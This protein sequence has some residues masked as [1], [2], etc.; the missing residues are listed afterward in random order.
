MKRLLHR[1][2]LCLFISL[3]TFSASQGKGFGDDLKF[4]IE[5][6]SSFDR[7][8]YFNE[9]L[10][11]F[12]DF[13]V[14]NGKR[15]DPFFLFTKGVTTFLQI[16]V[17]HKRLII[18]GHINIGGN[19]ESLVHE[20]GGNLRYNYNLSESPPFDF[21]KTDQPMKLTLSSTEIDLLLGWRFRPSFRVG[22]AIKRRNYKFLL[23]LPESHNGQFFQESIKFAFLG[24]YENLPLVGIRMNYERQVNP[25]RL[26][27]RI[28]IYPLARFIVSPPESKQTFS[29]GGM[30]LKLGAQW[31]MLTASY[32]FEY[33]RSNGGIVKWRNNSYQFGL[34]FTLI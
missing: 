12:P 21:V 18:E 17:K 13:E 15:I 28:T 24:S 19:Y 29:G 31:N 33:L 27:S 22:I 3:L 30:N 4:S 10:T 6:G 16:N 5:L 20:E 2:L 32:R 9:D 11:N 8:N 14:G 25:F 26:K 34:V 1:I 7:L 23:K